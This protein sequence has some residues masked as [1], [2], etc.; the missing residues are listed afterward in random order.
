MFGL[1]MPWGEFMTDR[2]GNQHVSALFVLMGLAR[3]VSNTELHEISGIRIDGA[4]RRQLNDENLVVS[5]RAKGNAP[6]VH[7]LTDKGWSRCEELLTAGRPERAGQLGHALH[8][9]LGGLDRYLRREKLRLADVFRPQA[10]LSR[11]EVERHIREAYARLARQP[12][13]W[14]RLADLRPL[15]NGA[16]REDVDGVLKDMSR[17]RRAQLAPDP[18]RKVLTDADHAAAVRIGGEDNHL[19]VIEP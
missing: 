13:D 9:V 10:E 15:L 5:A 16:T 14:V 1:G 8:V 4:V 18:N 12:K 7:E 3:S 2:L 17:A 6:F 19:I 11:D